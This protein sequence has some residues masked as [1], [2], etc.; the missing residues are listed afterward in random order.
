MTDLKLFSSD[1][2]RVFMLCPGDDKHTITAV[3]KQD[4]KWKVGKKAQNTT[5]MK[6]N[7]YFSIDKTQR[8]LTAATDA[9]VIICRNDTS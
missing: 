8:S 3:G 1:A 7:F 2:R 9:E 4:L 6:F 5:H